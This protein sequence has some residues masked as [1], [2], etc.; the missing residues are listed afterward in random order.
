VTF[1]QTYGI[2]LGAPPKGPKLG[3][4][5]RLPVKG[6]TDCARTLPAIVMA[7]MKKACQWMTEKRINGYG[8]QV[9]PDIST[10]ILT[11]VTV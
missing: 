4:N 9:T 7:M 10:F 1:C 3:L 5:P 2:L 11:Y 8:V 6:F